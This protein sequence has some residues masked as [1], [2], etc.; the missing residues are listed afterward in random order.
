[1]INEKNNG[2]KAFMQK[3]KGFGGT[4]PIFEEK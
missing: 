4:K 1:L 3:E 2:Q